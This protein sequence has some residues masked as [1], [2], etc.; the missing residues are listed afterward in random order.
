MDIDTLAKGIG[1]FSSAITAL[2]QAIELMPDGSKK[3]EAVAALQRAERAFKIA[4][5]ETAKKLDYELCHK[6][7]PPEIMLSGDDTTWK[8]PIC[9]NEKF[10][11]LQV[12][13]IP[14][15]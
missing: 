11:G 15:S 12:G 4:E 2:R 5:A 14:L 9:G 10:T 13:S 7:F 3:S 8:C 1:L 6:H